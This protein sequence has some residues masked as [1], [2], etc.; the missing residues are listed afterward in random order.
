MLFIILAADEPK[1]IAACAADSE[2][3]LLIQ[4]G[5]LFVGIFPD[6]SP[7]VTAESD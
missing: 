4:R 1:Q 7:G 3:F 2:I 6:P 5:D